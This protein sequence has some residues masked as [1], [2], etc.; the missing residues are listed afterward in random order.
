MV[1]PLKIGEKYSD[2]VDQL[3]VSHTT[4][5]NVWKTRE[6]QYR[7]YKTE[8]DQLKNIEDTDLLR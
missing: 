4:V 8:N 5:F 7:S 3:G 1:F 2:T 6:K